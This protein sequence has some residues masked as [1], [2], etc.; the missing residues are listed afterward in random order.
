VAGPT[1]FG[2]LNVPIVGIAVFALCGAFLPSVSKICSIHYGATCF[3]GEKYVVH[4]RHA[5]FRVVHCLLGPPVPEGD[6]KLRLVCS[7]C[8]FVNYRNP[9]IVVGSV[10]EDEQGRVLL[11]RRG[12]EPR[13]GAWNLPAGFMESNETLEEGTL[14]L[15]GVVR[16][17]SAVLPGKPVSNRISTCHLFTLFHQEPPGKPWKK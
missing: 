6:D 4:S 5:L 2:W 13:Y 17:W 9:K 11:G 8:G 1:S 14:P 10:V 12:I 7:S 3:C 15:H 16:V